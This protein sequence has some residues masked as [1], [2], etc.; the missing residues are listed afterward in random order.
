MLEFCV[1]IVLNEIKTRTSE[2]KRFIAA[3]F[4]WLF[5]PFSSKTNLKTIKINKKT[6]NYTNRVKQ[7][8]MNKRRIDI[9]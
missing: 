5:P 3:T 6:L 2:F 9:K 1:D 7:Q 4:R 8:L